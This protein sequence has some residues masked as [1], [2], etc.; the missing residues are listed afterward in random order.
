M[1]HGV[2]KTITITRMRRARAHPIHT[3]HLMQTNSIAD[4]LSHLAYS[5]HVRTVLRKILVMCLLC[6]CA[7]YVQYTKIM[8]LVS[9]SRREVDAVA[10]GKD[11][12]VDEETEIVVRN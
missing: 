5:T 11:D 2:W 6:F 10:E 9:R 3:T 4:I 1:A 12:E 8:I 7:I